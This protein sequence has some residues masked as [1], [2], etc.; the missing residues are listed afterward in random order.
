MQ[1]INSFRKILETKHSEEFDGMVVDIPCAYAVVF[2]H[3]EMTP[4]N[5]V[6]FLSMPL[7]RMLTIAKQF[8]R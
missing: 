5:K 3:D 4:D 7:T 6:K 1:D 2:V 8:V